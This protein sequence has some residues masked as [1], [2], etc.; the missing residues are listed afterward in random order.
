MALGTEVTRFEHP[1]LENGSRYI[2]NPSVSYPLLAPGWFVIPKLQ[3]HLTRYELDQTLRPGAN[4]RSRALPITSLDAGLVFERDARWFGAAV[5]QTLEPRLFYSY[6]PF[7]PQN[8][9]PNFDSA[10][11]DFNFAQLFN[12]NVFVGGDR[13]GEA[14]QVTAALVARILDSQTGA[15]R[16]RAAI[17]QRYYYN[18]QRVALPGGTGLRDDDSSDVLF[19]LNGLIARHWVAD[20]ALQHSTAQNQVVRATLGVRYQPRAASVLSLAYRYKVGAAAQGGLN[21]VDV[22]GQWPITNRWYGVARANYSKLD[23]RWIETL[24]GFEYKADCWV[25]RFAAQRFATTQETATTQFFFAIELNGLGSVGTSPVE[26]LRRNIPGYQL[27]NPPP[28]E[29]GRFDYY[30]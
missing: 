8:D 19:G 22:A 25:L 1:T 9:L 21:Q 27:I 28:R 14:N 4:E 3:A 6:I 10:L 15:E 16:L 24:A 30:E 20:I 18:P 29:P 12:E 26:Q 5:T 13:I 2:A 23:R 7:R 17:G 11:A